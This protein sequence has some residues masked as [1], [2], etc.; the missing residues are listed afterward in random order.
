[1]VYK[2]PGVYVEEIALFPPSVAEVATAIPAFIGY[3]EKAV[4]NGESLTNKP[5]RITS[6]LEYRD[7]FGGEY[8]PTSVTVRVDTE[9][10]VTSA[11]MTRFYLYDCLRLYFDNGGGPCYIVSVGRYTTGNSAT[12]IQNG[13][14]TNPGFIPGLKALEKYDEPTIILF[15]DAAQ[16]TAVALHALQQ[17]ALSQCGRLQDRVGLFD[18]PSGLTKNTVPAFRDAIGINDLKYGMAYVPWVRTAYDPKVPFSMIRSSVYRGTAQAPLELKDLTSDPELN[19]LV[20]AAAAAVDDVALVDT[21]LATLRATS[22]S[23]RDRYATLRKA[24]TMANDDAT[25]KTAFLALLAFVHQ[26]AVAIPGWRASVKNEQIKQDLDTYAVAK[27]RAPVEQLV[28]FE[29]NSWVVT[30]MGPGA[31]T[32]T[33][34]LGTAYDSPA[35][36]WLSKTVSTI[37]ASTVDYGNAATG[38]TGGP[39]SGKDASQLAAADIDP[40]FKGIEGLISEVTTAARTR[41][42]IAEQTL[43]QRHSVIAS[44]VEHLKREMRTLPPS[45]AVA[46]VYAFVDRTR[47]VWKAPANVSLAAVVEPAE[48]I[49]TATQEDLNVDVTG[50]KSINVIR[51]F[52]GR[53]T[54]VWGART[55]A[56]NDNEWRYIPVRR[57][58]NMVEESVKKS[59]AW[60]VF[61]PNA[62]PLWTKVKSMIDNY[63]VQKWRDGALAGATPDDAFFVNVGL[64]TTMT[65]IDILEGR[66]IVEIGMAVVRPAEF[67]ILK[68][69]HKM[70]KS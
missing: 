11:T 29:K 69:S 50:G 65:A 16:L 5:T 33:A 67:I 53:G 60:A 62:A 44:I 37:T 34:E 7:L 42:G 39:R 14:E 23:L 61:E 70:Q 66:L 21:R 58:Y 4:L 10:A 55:L 13:D 47:G 68:F 30:Q 45:G 54:L 17:A 24:V 22:P 26:V 64:G 57:F 46:G 1:M 28:A 49:D 56:G 41:A 38:A 9:N 6:L 36:S 52:T 3:T 19:K 27:L 18:L 40:V 31:T 32:T 12:T 63:L 8:Q 59:T 15:P 25:A 51:A 43:Y 48:A 20:I 35:T 2:S